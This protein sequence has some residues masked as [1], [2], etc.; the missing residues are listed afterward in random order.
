MG[1]SRSTRPGYAM[2]K[3]IGRPEDVAAER[4]PAIGIGPHSVWSGPARATAPGAPLVRRA[5][6][7]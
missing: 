5:K 2:R 7:A 3:N 4:R 1:F 6:L